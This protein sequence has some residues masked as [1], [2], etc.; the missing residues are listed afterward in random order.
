[1]ASTPLGPLVLGRAEI[2]RDS[3]WNNLRRFVLEYICT[4]IYGDSYWNNLWGSYWNNL[5][6][7]DGG[8]A[9]AAVV[10]HGRVEVDPAGEAVALQRAEE[11]HDSADV[12]PVS[13]V[14][15]VS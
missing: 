7:F 3:Y 11:P 14:F 12:Q 1:M 2:T 6:R 13:V 10:R 5:Q 4:R 9:P 8:T 15:C